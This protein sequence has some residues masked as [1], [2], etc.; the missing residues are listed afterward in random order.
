MEKV[1]S[2]CHE[3]YDWS[4]GCTGFRRGVVGIEVCMWKDVGSVCDGSVMMI[5]WRVCGMPRA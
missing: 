4:S 2:G 5:W 1:S 3:L